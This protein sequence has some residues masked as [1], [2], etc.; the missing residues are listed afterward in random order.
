M[1]KNLISKTAKSHILQIQKAMR[2]NKL[3]VLVGAG[4]S[5]SCGVPLWSE[6]IEELKN[7]LDFQENET[8]FLKIPQLYKNMRKHKEY[9]ERIKEILL[10]GKVQCK[11]VHDAILDLNPCHIITTNYDD[12]LEQA[13]IKRHEQFFTVRKDE[14]LPYNHGERMLLKMHGSFDADNIVLT[15]NDY[16][17]YARNFP[18]MRSYV[19]SLFASKLVLLVGFSFSDINLKYILRDVRQCLGDKM[20]SLY[21]LSAKPLDFHAQ[22]Y[23]DTNYIHVVNI[24]DE[25]AKNTMDMQHVEYKPTPFEDPRS[26]TL[27]HQLVLLQKYSEYGNDAIGIVINFLADYADQFTYIGKYIKNLFPRE[28]R[29]SVS[30]EY[31][32]LKLPEQYKKSVER[33]V[34]NDNEAKAYRKHNKEDLEKV[35]LW[36]NQN[37]IDSIEKPAIKLDHFLQNIQVEEVKHPMRMFYE[38]DF[39]S[40]TDWMEEQKGKAWTFTKSDLIYP[41]MLCKCGRYSE[42]YERFKLMGD[43]MCQRNRHVLYFLCWY[44]IRALYGPVLNEIVGGGKEAWNR[45]NNEIGKLDL[46]RII[47]SLPVEGAMKDILSELENGKYLSN[48]LIDAESFCQKLREQR[49]ASE[50]GGTSINSDINHVLNSFDEI[51]NYQVSNCIFNEPYKHSQTTNLRIAEGVLQSVMTK[52]N[53]G[54][55]GPT[56][57]P[58]LYGNLVRLFVFG[59]QTDELRKLLYRVVGDNKLPFDESF[60]ATVNQ[61]LNNL[62]LY[63]KEYGTGRGCMNG[64]IIGQ[65]IMNIMWMALYTDKPLNMPHIFELIAGYWFEGQMIMQNKL[66]NRFF[67]NYDVPGNDAV[68]IMNQIMHNN[69][70]VTERIQTAIAN[71]CY[72]I[73]K[74]NLHIEEL[75]SIRQLEQ[76]NNIEFIASFCNGADNKVKKEIVECLQKKSKCLY[77]LVEA[78][79]LSGER[80]ITTELLR[81]YKDVV[82]VGYINNIFPDEFVYANLASMSGKEH[83]KDIKDV[84]EECF[85]DN[86]CYKFMKDPQ[87]YEGLLSEIP[88]QWLMYLSDEDLKVMLLNPLIRR[89]YRDFCDKNT[90]AVD[91]KK[92]LWNMM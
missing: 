4:A 2:Q 34:S 74:D 92:K 29:N 60:E 20:Q 75:I 25:D 56:K 77:H 46:K 83:W 19:M 51:T 58:V 39:C 32:A 37:D 45:I 43:I 87:H 71:L 67:Y 57:L 48:Q 27:Y 79:H 69:Q 16:L 90:W 10:D 66:M 52:E 76:S 6:L 78:E 15:E 59:L 50:K 12:L 14:D 86:V 38:M 17:D 24:S 1:E 8:D 41:Y 3:V 47:N 82:K 31:G 64:K 44:N 35:L 28:C 85:K 65:Y 5:K 40:L 54:K 30:V 49:E 88:G 11:E 26:N 84:I 42:A 80:I 63:Y 89:N 91:M 53:E 13:F 22:T 7:E 33:I 61:T 36:L 81:K 9:H 70:S 72:H 55:F 68:L 73:K 18:L 21:M 23:L 62:Y